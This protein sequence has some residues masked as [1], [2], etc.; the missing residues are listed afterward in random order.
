MYPLISGDDWEFPFNQLRLRTWGDTARYMY[1]GMKH[2]DVGLPM[3]IELTF[4]RR[5]KSFVVYGHA[6]N[7][8]DVT[9]CSDVTSS[10]FA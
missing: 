3:L 8:G 9:H 10:S 7:V 6:R 5:R 2:A 1:E 4:E